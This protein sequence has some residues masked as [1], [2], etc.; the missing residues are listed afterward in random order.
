ML[1]NTPT[2]WTGALNKESWLINLTRTATRSCRTRKRTL[3]FCSSGVVR[4]R[5]QPRCGAA[6]SGTDC[7]ARRCW[8]RC[9]WCFCCR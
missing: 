1:Y 5:L 7:I 2:K 4:R 6:S 8:C 3:H 9:C